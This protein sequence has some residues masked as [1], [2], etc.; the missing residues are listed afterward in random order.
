MKKSLILITVI[1][2]VLTSLLPAYAETPD[3][4]LINPYDSLIGVLTTNPHNN[5]LI[6]KTENGPYEL[7]GDTKGMDAYIG[8]TVEVLGYYIMTFA[9]TEFPLFNVV[10]YRVIKT[11]TIKGT[12]CSYFKQLY[13]A[14]DTKDRYKLIGNTSGIDKYIGKKIEVTGII[15]GSQGII[16]PP[17]GVMAPSILLKNLFVISFKELTER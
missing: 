15:D 1:L 4:S 6:L 11:V 3:D 17:D 5:A 14:S 13:L 10:S 16:N 2:F 8:M 12:V 7:W 9:P